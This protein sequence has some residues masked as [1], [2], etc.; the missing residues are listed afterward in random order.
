MRS[1]T[2]SPKMF[3]L[4]VFSLFMFTHATMATELGNPSV[5]KVPYIELLLEQTAAPQSQAHAFSASCCKTCRKGKACGNS[6][7]SKKKRCT[8]GAGCACDG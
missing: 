4:A 8:R 3:S 6:C 1:L 7:I 5:Y 2:F